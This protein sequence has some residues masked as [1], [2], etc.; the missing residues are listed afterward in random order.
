[1][2]TV[3]H[4]PAHAKMY[5]TYSLRVQTGYDVH[6][7]SHRYSEFRELYLQ[8][9]MQFGAPRLGEFPPKA[10]LSGSWLGVWKHS[11]FI[12][13]RAE[14]LGAFMAHICRDNELYTHLSVRKFLQ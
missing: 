8:L 3:A 2:G 9:Q 10:M 5:T 11:A 1:V 6:Y 12:Q 4:Q 7:V 14:K 13:M